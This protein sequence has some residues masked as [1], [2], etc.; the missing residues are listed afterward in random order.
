MKNILV[1]LA[2][3]PNCGK[4]TMFNMLTGAHQ[5][6]AN[7]PGVTVE[8]KSGAFE[9]EDKKIQIVDLPGTYGL[10]SWSL[11]EKVS[12]EFIVGE[13]IDQL[14]AAMDAS[15]LEKSIYFCLQLLE[16]KKPTIAALNML[17]V[18]K[19]RHIEVNPELLSQKLGI[20]V[21]P[22]QAN[23]KIGKT[24]LA[25]SIADQ[26]GVITKGPD[27]DYGPLEP[28]LAKL[29]GMLPAEGIA[30][31]PARWLAIKLIENDTLAYKIVGS[32]EGGAAICQVA[33]EEIARIEK[34]Q[35]IDT[36]RIVGSARY[37]KARAIAS[38]C[39]KREQ[40]VVSA[41]EQA[42]SILCHRILGPIVMI[43]ILFI[44]YVC[45]VTYGNALTPIVWPVWGQLEIW[46]AQI[47]PAPG[48]IEDPLL[49]AMGNWVVKSITA[50]LNYLP[51]FV[52]M[53]ALVAILEESGYM[54]RIAFIMDRLFHRMGL[55]GQSTLPLILGGLYVG[56]CAIP[57]VIATKAIP[58]DRA[59]MATILIT[60]M[61]NCLAKVPLYLLLVDAFFPTTAG[62]TMF[63]I[64]TVTLLTG[65]I[66]AKFL[67]LTLL[68]DVPSAPFIIEMPIYHM[69]T[70]QGVA[71]QTIARIWLFLKKITTIIIAVAII[72][73]VLINFPNLSQERQDYYHREQEKLEQQFMQAVDG[74]SFKGQLTAKDIVPLIAFQD[75][76]KQEKRGVSQEKANQINEA[77]K[78]KNPI[79]AAIV[80]KQGKDGK[81]LAKVFK[82][83]ETGRKNL[84]RELREERFQGSFL[85][86][87]GRALEPLT[88]YAGFNWQVNVALLSAFAAKENSAATL[89][90]IYGIS[91]QSIG[92]GLRSNSGF[93]PLH[94][95][96][97]M[98]FM[99][100]Y[101]PCIAASVMVKVQAGSSKWMI[102][103]IIFQMFL[104]IVVAIV[105][106]SG[107]TAL[108][109]TAT[110]AM[111]SYYGFLV[112]LLALMAFIPNR[113][114]NKYKVNPQLQTS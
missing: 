59:R 108:G 101:P 37:R 27:V 60:P 88:K 35:N 113:G 82:K 104:G 95:L 87:A 18:A 112:V 33:Q 93:T 1:A 99:S 13:K 84:R 91:G 25:K 31:Y 17:D 50:V 46:A 51:I 14:I 40:F 111:W 56:G 74:S 73:F 38:E 79:Y 77:A 89:G 34:E 100:L 109:L 11:E 7:Y 58:D 44:F 103:S 6:I 10:T 71:S 30:E 22:V 75:D 15:T 81:N 32:I 107:A 76:L 55:H 94:A 19:K 23:K 39:T 92:E 52:I 26:Q 24:E 66:V 8:K 43:G 70:V 4:S 2:G 61:M 53:F 41:T 54:A 69:P 72:I 67:T 29:E 102:F 12:R 110:Q 57:A 90:A 80:L 63:F 65:L 83:I 97:L 98:L 96:A 62:T 45:S 20:P 47:L 105:V 68:K 16:L 85:G 42:D 28:S 36:P 3:Q 21:V 86:M 64:G 106:F 49:T 5:H 9:F 114:E 78:A 48:F